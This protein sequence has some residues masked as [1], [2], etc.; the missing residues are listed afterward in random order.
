MGRPINKRYFG[1]N[2]SNN[3]RVQFNNG[4]ASVAGAIVKQKGSKRFECVDASGAKA[5]CKLASKADADLLSGEMSI[6]VLNDAG[7]ALY[8]TKISARKVTASD[9]MTYPWTFAASSVDNAVQVEEAG[10][11]GEFTASVDLTP[12]G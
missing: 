9:G 12:E 4:S 5:I 6:T 1:A 2:A 8:V 10:T 11:D 3:L 7:D